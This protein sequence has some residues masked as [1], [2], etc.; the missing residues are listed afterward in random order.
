MIQSISTAGA[1]PALEMTL[2]FAGARQRVIAHNIANFDT[3]NFRPKDADP[4]DFQRVLGE[5]IEG[6]RARNGGVSGALDWQESSQIKRGPSGSLRLNPEAD[7][8]NILFH[9]RNNRD[10][11]RTMQDLVENAG[12]YRV[13]SDLL[14]NR[15]QIIQAA[16]A[17]RV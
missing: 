12:V 8:G 5:A 15:F 11:E 14:R 17:E 13:A 9:D 6:R 1:I 4:R 7:S 3:P 2:Q 10:L 16:I